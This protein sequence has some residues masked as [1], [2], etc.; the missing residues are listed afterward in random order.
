MKQWILQ[1]KRALAL[2]A[3]AA[4]FIVLGIFRGEADT[5]LRKAVN[6]CMEC[7]GLG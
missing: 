1:N 3:L 5:V 6:V 2:I 4:A 7:I